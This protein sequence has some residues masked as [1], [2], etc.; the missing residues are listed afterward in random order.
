ME[1]WIDITDQE[2]TTDPVWQW[3]AE[4]EGG[5][6]A[7]FVGATRRITG[8]RETVKLSYESHETMARKEMQRLADEA[9]TKW[10]LLRVAVLHRVGEV[11]VSQASVIIGVASAHR[12]PAFEASRWLIDELKVSVPIWK[13]EHFSDGSTEWQGDTWLR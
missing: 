5:G 12:A 4:S 13:Q 7:I 11:P 1:T 8:E 3:L 2:L 6:I 9:G 10:R